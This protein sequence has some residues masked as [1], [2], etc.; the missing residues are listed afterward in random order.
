MPLGDEIRQLVRL[1]A[2]F[3]IHENSALSMAS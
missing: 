2:H 3:C 1:A